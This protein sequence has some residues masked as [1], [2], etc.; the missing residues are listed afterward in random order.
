MIRYLPPTHEC[1]K[2]GTNGYYTD[3]KNG[4]PHCKHGSKK[5]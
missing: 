3:F 4:C 2:C 5:D 1:L